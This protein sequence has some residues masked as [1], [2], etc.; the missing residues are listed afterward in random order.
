M[1][2]ALDAGDWIEALEYPAPGDHPDAGAWV[3][4]LFTGESARGPRQGGRPKVD[5]AA[6][7][8]LWLSAVPYGLW[9]KRVSEPSMEEHLQ[10]VRRLEQVLGEAIDHY[11]LR[12][13]EGTTLTDLAG[14]VASLIEGA[15][16]NQCLTTRHPSD[17]SETSATFLRR[18][19]R[20][21]WE[22]ATE[23]RVG[24]AG[25]GAGVTAGPASSSR[26]RLRS[27]RRTSPS[28]SRCTVRT[29]ESSSDSSSSPNW[30]SM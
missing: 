18:S 29:C 7:W 16:L 14:A 9:S 20:L 12:L 30:V 21:L 25:Y 23:P 28:K 6:L 22:G 11:R 3:D 8:A 1:E 15:W 17:P 26:S 2:R 5:Y 24:V 27:S 10:W 4:A 19:G 13:R